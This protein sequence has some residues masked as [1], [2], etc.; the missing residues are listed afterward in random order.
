MKQNKYDEPGFF[1]KYMQ[2]PSSK[3]GLPEY[4]EWPA[5]QTALPDLKGKRV[6]DLGCG[7]GWHCRYAAEQGAAAIVGLDLSEKMLERARSLHD[8]LPID[9]RH[10][11]MEDA[12]IA[13]GSFDV[14]M[15]SVA[16][17]YVEDYRALCRRTYQ[18]LVPGGYFVFSTNHPVFTAIP[19][20]E[21]IRYNQNEVAWPLD[22]YFSEGPRGTNFLEPGVIMYHRTIETHVMGL[23]EAGFAIRELREPAPTEE[24]IAPR[25]AYMAYERRRPRFL[26][27]SAQRS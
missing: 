6:L 9:F 5:F 13:P 1:A 18:L 25:R 17:N 14:V 4:H 20:Q 2:F 8:G 19:R 27:L 15:S 12:N 23:I 10:G 7:F 16:V 21:F 24:F 26:L 3:M 22:I 11:D